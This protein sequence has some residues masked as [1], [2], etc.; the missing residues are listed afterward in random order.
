MVRKIIGVEALRSLSSI[1]MPVL[2]DPRKKSLF[3][4]ETNNKLEWGNGMVYVNSVSKMLDGESYCA[5]LEMRG[6]CYLDIEFA[7]LVRPYYACF[8]CHFCGVDKE[9]PRFVGKDELHFLVTEL[10]KFLQL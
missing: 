7:G 5:Y 3:S 8:G 10:L 9:Q 1:A 6:I 4:A 2:L